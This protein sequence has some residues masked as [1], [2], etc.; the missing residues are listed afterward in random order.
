MPALIVIAKN[1][2]TS[3]IYLSEFDLTIPASGQISLTDF[4]TVSEINGDAQLQDLVDIGQVVL[5]DGSMD[6]PATVAS[7]VGHGTQTDPNLHAVATGSTS[8]FMNPVDK[9]KLDTVTAGAEPNTVDSVFGRTG[10]V[11]AQSGDYSASE[12]S[13]DSS[14]TGATVSAALD[15]L[16]SSIVP[17]LVSSVFGRTG[18]VIA[19]SG[20][21]NASQVT[22]SPNGDITATN[23]QTAIVELRDDA[24]SK[25]LL[26]QDLS[27]KGVANGYA[28]LDG[29]GTVPISQLPAGIVGAL[30]FQG[31]WN[32]STNTPTLSNG[33][34][35]GS[36]G[37][38]YIISVAG[39]TSVDGITDWQ[40]GDWIVNTGASW[41]KIDNTDSVVSVNGLTGAV[42]INL[43][44]LGTG[45]LAQLN[46]LVT[47]ANLV[48]ESRMVIAGS[49]LTG[50]GDLSTDRSFAVQAADSSISITGSGV[51]V[52]IITDVQHGSRS[53]GNLHAT[54]TTSTS[55]FMSSVDKTTLDATDAAGTPRPPTSH[56]SSHERGGSDEID[57][58]HL[59]I[60]FTPSNYTPSVTPPEAA[61]VDDLSAHLAGIDDALST[62][63]VS[64]GDFISAYDSAGGTVVN[65]VVQ[66]VPFGARH[67]ITSGFTHTLGSGEVTV[68]TTGTYLIDGNVSVD[69]A[70]SSSRSSATFWLE[71]DRGS[72]F[73][74]EPGTRA[75]SYHRVSS[76][77]EDTGSFSLVLDLDS[78]D[79][80][81][82]RV[83]RRAGGANMSLLVN[84]SRLRLSSTV[85]PQGP[86]GPAGMG[87]IT[88]EDEGATVTGGPHTT[89]DYTGEL[90]SV[91]DAGSS[92]AT[93]NVRLPFWAAFKNDAQQTVSPGPTTVG[94]LN[95][96]TPRAG[97]YKVTC[98]SEVFGTVLGSIQR[99]QYQV[100]GVDVGFMEIPAPQVDT[101]ENWPVCISDH[102]V[103]TQGAH[104]VTAILTQFS[105]GGSAQIRR[106]RLQVEEKA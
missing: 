88:L 59:D 49:G 64:G 56:A 78:G 101:T 45:T 55:G 99:L 98:S 36:T 69:N 80:L 95:F 3:P 105:G 20:D 106:L 5:N 9:A 77:G 47:D 28:S 72:G 16:S 94:T 51:A 34:V 31:T 24:D 27:E 11:T 23:T 74:E 53:G 40:V 86:A 62:V 90:V 96:T 22:F 30:V 32:A 26:K 18:A 89:V 7:S 2:T 14:V 92:E 91:S 103:L 6:L 29:S 66:T 71:V 8:G 63:L 82:M 70:T 58:D 85:G 43:S 33:G 13:N 41:E 50:G 4:L 84:G 37:H 97:T 35:G 54:A 75:F 68:N 38:F 76:A 73:V 52:G 81:R 93:V 79:V 10:A 65:S 1:Q 104:T 83:Q 21:Y 57:G 48:P 67:K 42:T 12:V 25:L 60:D 15:N 19:Q 61:N 17:A 46:A 100:D 102:L 39:S 87:G 44:N